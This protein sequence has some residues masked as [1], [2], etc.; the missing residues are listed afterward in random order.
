MPCTLADFWR[1]AMEK[2]FIDVAERFSG[3]RKMTENQLL[4]AV[5]SK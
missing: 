5:F 1:D 3:K 2:F 4:K